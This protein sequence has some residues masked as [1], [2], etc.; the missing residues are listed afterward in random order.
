MDGYLQNRSNSTAPQPLSPTPPWYNNNTTIDEPSNQPHQQQ[1]HR[2]SLPSLSTPSSNTLNQ[3]HHHHQYHPRQHSL[4]QISANVATNPMITTTPSSSS[5]LSS[6]SATSS[7]SSIPPPLQLLPGTSSDTG[8]LQQDE[9]RRRSSTSQEQSITRIDNDVNE[10]IRHCHYLSDNMTQQKNQLLDQDYFCDSTKVRP[11]LDGMIGRANEVL[12]ALLRLR[13]Q[14]M[15]AEISRLHGT[16]GQSNSDDG[17]DYNPQ[18]HNQENDLNNPRFNKTSGKLDGN[19]HTIRQKKR[20]R[21][22]VFQGRCHSCNISETPE[23]RRGPDGARTLCNA[24]GLH[25]AKLARKK[26]EQ[27]KEQSKRGK[28]TTYDIL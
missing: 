4:P 13:K 18:D 10:V 24:C 28:R 17:D 25:Y 11:W 21:R 16:A 26:A 2:T 22:S 14:Q 8:F 12:N 7:S 15:T 19:Y 9:K 23:W 3:H 20:G 27:Q 6:S 5:P 1:Q